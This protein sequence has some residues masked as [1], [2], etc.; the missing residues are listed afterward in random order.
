MDTLTIDDVFQSVI[1]AT[2]KSF[3]NRVLRAAYDRSSTTWTTTRTSLLCTS[4]PYVF[5]HFGVAR[6][7]A[8]IHLTAP[9]PRA[10]RQLTRTSPVK[11]EKYNKYKHQGGHEHIVL[12]CDTFEQHGEKL[13]K[14]LRR[15]GLAG[16]DWNEF[17]AV[18]ALFMAAQKHFPGSVPSD[19]DTD[20]DYAAA[21]SES[22]DSN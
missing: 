16:A 1:L 19:A 6:S 3:N 20:D 12:F 18:T 4:K 2:L 10:P 13:E 14:V 11:T 21:A 15:A 9:T 22:D 5:A 17:T 7:D 8:R